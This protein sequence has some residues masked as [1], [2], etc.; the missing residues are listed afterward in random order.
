MGSATRH[1][2]AVHRVVQ[3][4]AGRSS[5][6]SGTTMNGIRGT[7]SDDKLYTLYCLTHPS[8]LT[9]VIG[10]RMKMEAFLPAIPEIAKTL[11]STQADGHR[12]AVAITTTGGLAGGRSADGMLE[13]LP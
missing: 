11:G 9:G 1:P 5:S 8:W 2:A 13:P 12:A 6:S 10:R 7:I 3:M 4:I